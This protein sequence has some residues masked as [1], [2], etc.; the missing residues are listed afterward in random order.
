MKDKKIKTEY[1]PKIISIWSRCHSPNCNY[2]LIEE[3]VHIQTDYKSGVKYSKSYGQKILESYELDKD[4][5]NPEA[6]I[7]N[8]MS[9]DNVAVKDYAYYRVSFANGSDV[10]C[11]SYKEYLTLIK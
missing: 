7:K 2:L 3:T 9:D 6:F 1:I 8:C 10:I 11:K 5:S 4:N